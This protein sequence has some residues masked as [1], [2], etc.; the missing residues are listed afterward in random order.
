M[1][2]LSSLFGGG[3]EDP[4]AIRQRAA[5]QAAEQARQAQEAENRRNQMQLDY[6]NQ[7]RAD[8]Q[9][10]QAKIEAADPTATRTAALQSL[11]QR[12]APGFETNYLP[13][14]YDDPLAG[15]VYGEQRTKAEDY[16]GNLFKRGVITD[17]GRGAAVAS[18]DEQAPRVRTQLQGI[19]QTLLNAER[20]KLG[21]IANTG[22]QAASSLGVG[23]AFS[24]D[25]Y[26]T[27]IQSSLGDFGK[28]FGDT[29][30]A[31]LPGDLFDTS[32]LASV[33]GGAQGALNTPFDPNAVAGPVAATDETDPFSG[34][35]PVQKRTSTVF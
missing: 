3:G 24:A 33:A 8:E 20:S 9:A 18:L 19:G 15:Q 34:Q 27:Q 26:E 25:P 4:E 28:S 17:T 30:R 7:L 11:D 23:Q 35:K 13:D 22:R 12:F 31:G 10:Q 2:W 21:G 1:S 29:F 16:I 6:L 32:S 5:G 14:T